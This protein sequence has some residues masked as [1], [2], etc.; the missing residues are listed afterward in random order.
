MKL[1]GVVVLYNPSKDVKDNI[2]SYLEFLDKLYVIDNSS[3]S[4]EKDFNDEKMEYIH[5][6]ENMG[7]AYPLNLGCVLAI[8]DRF[9]WLL[10]MDQDTKFNSDVLPVLIDYIENNDTSKDGIVTVWHESN[11]D[12]EKTKDK[13]DYPLTEMTSGN[14]LN[15]DIYKIVGKFREDFFIDGVDI[16]YCLRLKKKGY[17]IVRFNNVFINHNLGNIEYHKLFGKRFLC[18]NHNYIRNYYMQRNYRYINEEYKGIAPDYCDMLIHIKLRIFKI[19]MFEKDKYRKI[20]NI[21]R[22]IKDYKKGIK[23]KYRFNN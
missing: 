18:T 2:N 15:L 5:Q 22:G 8:R 21:F 7:I 16:E 4:H 23:G 10:T 20:R 6:D 3:D 19:L 14:L 12:V 17:R 9:N 1:A 13:I 11:L